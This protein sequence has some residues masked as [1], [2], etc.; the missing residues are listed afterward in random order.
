MG[1]KP[2]VSKALTVAPP[3]LLSSQAQDL[4]NQIQDL[5]EEGKEM[6]ERRQSALLKNPRYETL[7]KQAASIVKEAGDITKKFDV[8]HPK[9]K[10][11]IDAINHEG[12]MV[13]IGLAKI[14][15]EAIRKG[16][17]LEIYQGS[18]KSKKRVRLSFSVQPTLFD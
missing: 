5:K 2:K 16:V 6:R 10:Q 1:R 15:V 14:A 4:Y 12:K 18:G 7:K 8:A 9:F 11:D 17:D 3:R 13:F